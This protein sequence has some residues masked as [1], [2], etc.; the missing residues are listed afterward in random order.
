MC[1]NNIVMDMCFILGI[2]QNHLLYGNRG[3]NYV[4]LPQAHDRIS[5]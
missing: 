5:G 4:F 1:N 2:Y 3:L